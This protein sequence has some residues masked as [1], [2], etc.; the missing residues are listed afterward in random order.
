M[1]D[2]HARLL[3]VH[4]IAETASQLGAVSQT[5][6]PFITFILPLALSDDLIMHSLLALSGAH[7]S[8]EKTWDAQIYLT[9]CLHYAIVVHYLQEAFADDAPIKLPRVLLAT[10]MLCTFEVRWL[11]YF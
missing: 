9:T 1:R 11:L 4:Y 2:P 6:T 7:L 8:H 5:E 3:F 10:L